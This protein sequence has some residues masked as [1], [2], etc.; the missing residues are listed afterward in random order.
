MSWFLPWRRAEFRPLYPAAAPGPELVAL[1]A[2][3]FALP[4][5][6]VQTWYE[7]YQQ[8]DQEQGYLRRFGEVETLCFAEAFLCYV[9]FAHFR[10]QR[11][12]EIGTQAG[13]ST[14]RLLDMATRLGLPRR[15]VCYDLVDEL[16]FC[17]RDE[18]ELVLTDV[19][20]HAAARVFTERQ[21]QF[22]YLDARP[23]YLLRDVIQSFLQA[24]HCPLLAI[25][26]C[27]P[28]LCNPQLRVAHDHPGGLDQ[29]TGG[30][31]R[32][33]LAGLL[34][35]SDPLSPALDDLRTATH[36]LRIFPT[37]HGLA[38]IQRLAPRP[39]SPAPPP[40]PAAIAAPTA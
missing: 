13:K 9:A 28:G 20:G 25:H 17:P 32:Q 3:Y 29:E 10:P 7:E 11:L 33:V 35:V 21:P 31:E 4:V 23:Y 38:F 6:Q 34:G 14:R 18:A 22:V 1:A 16:V 36:H 19:T 37:P 27:G 30:W 8:V 26:D 2:A 15:I 39:A 24:P 5:P 40:A 12:V